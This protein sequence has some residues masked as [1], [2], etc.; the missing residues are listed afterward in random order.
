MTMTLIYLFEIFCKYEFWLYS[1]N[2]KHKLVVTSLCFGLI[3]NSYGVSSSKNLFHQSLPDSREIILNN[4]CFRFP[5]IL[6]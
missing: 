2:S 5:F 1:D 4:I 6:I 3:A